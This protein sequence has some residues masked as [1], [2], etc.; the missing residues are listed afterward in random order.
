MNFYPTEKT[1]VFIDGPDLHSIARSTGVDIDFKK[2]KSFFQDRTH[3]VRAFYYTTVVVQDQHATIKPLVD[4][5]EY[6]GFT[7][8]TKPAKV[9]IAPDGRQH[10]NTNMRVELA[11]DALE[12]SQTADHVVL[13]SSDSAYCHLI[14]TLQRRGKRVSIVSTLANNGSAVADDLRRQADQFIDLVDIA[15]SI[16]RKIKDRTEPTSARTPV[17]AHAA[18]LDLDDGT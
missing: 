3:L 16:R 12:F 7:L 9:R 4:W 18:D 17:P 6:N 15:P 5:L 10:M 1:I 2:L 11:V 8:V 13:F 14:A